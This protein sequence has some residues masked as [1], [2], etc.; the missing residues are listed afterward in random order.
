MCKGE[1]PIGTANGKQTKIMASPP[2]PPFPSPGA[3]GGG[4]FPG[5]GGHGESRVQLLI[6]SRVVQCCSI[7]EALF[8]H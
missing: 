3:G 1:R 6:P 8:C 7:D 5:G 4:V 2:P